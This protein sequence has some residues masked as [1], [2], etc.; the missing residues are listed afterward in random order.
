MGPP[1]D[2][3]ILP[4]TSLV[5]GASESSFSFRQVDISGQS[6]RPVV[7]VDLRYLALLLWLRAESEKHLSV[8]DPSL[9]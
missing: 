4:N 7:I 6:L 9:R 2:E 5:F 8:Q 1:D 3:A